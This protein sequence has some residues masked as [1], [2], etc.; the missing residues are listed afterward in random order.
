MK[1]IFNT[2]RKIISLYYG[3]FVMPLVLFVAIFFPIMAISDAITIIST[4][5]TVTGDYIDIF[6]GVILLVYIYH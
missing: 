4:G 1:F 5:Y 3:I 2:I 6:L